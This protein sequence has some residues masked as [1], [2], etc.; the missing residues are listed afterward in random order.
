MCNWQGYDS[1]YQNLPGHGAVKRA[2]SEVRASC[3]VSLP[4]SAACSV[5]LGLWVL[6][7]KSLFTSVPSSSLCLFSVQYTLDYIYSKH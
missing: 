5:G 3:P 4:V 6:K 1:C 2:G 7:V